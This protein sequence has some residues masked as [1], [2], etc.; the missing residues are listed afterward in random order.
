MHWYRKDLLMT[1]RLAMVLVG[2]RTRGDV[3]YYKKLKYVEGKLR[4]F[5][6]GVLMVLVV[7]V[8][9]ALALIKGVDNGSDGKYVPDLE[10]NGVLYDT[11]GD[12]DYYHWVSE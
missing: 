1:R 5:I 6:V 2:K 12:G 3:G 4:E 10:V 8:L 7:I 9:F 11:D